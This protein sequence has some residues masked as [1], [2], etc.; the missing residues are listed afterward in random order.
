MANQ[1]L[2]AYIKEAL[3]Q[4]AARQAIEEALASSGW[5]KEEVAEAFSQVLPP[6]AKSPQPYYSVR[7]EHRM[8]PLVEAE[9]PS[10]GELAE[11]EALDL[12]GEKAP[13]PADFPSGRVFLRQ[14][15]DIFRDRM[16]IFVG[17]AAVP[18]V[19]SFLLNFA[20]SLLPTPSG[21]LLVLVFYFTLY[22]AIVIASFILQV[23]G[24]AALI[25]VLASEEKEIGVKE[26]YQ[27]SRQRLRPFLW[28]EVILALILAGGTI[29]FVVPGI[30]FSVWFV[31]APFILLTEDVKSTEA[32]FRSRYYIKGN[33]WG[34]VRRL[35]YLSFFAFMTLVPFLFLDLL[36]DTDLTSDVGGFATALI[37]VPLATTYTFLIYK[38][39]KSFKKD[40]KPPTLLPSFKK[41]V[42]VIAL[43]GAL[44]PLAFG[45]VVLLALNPSEVMEGLRDDQRETD[46]ASIQTALEIHYV[47]N[48]SYPPSLDELKNYFEEVPL[49]PLTDAPYQY[50]VAEEGMGYELCA[51]FE[52]K[53][54]RCV[55]RNVR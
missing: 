38:H 29:L 31:L 6:S 7:G 41:L 43:L 22:L 48:N 40:E 10:E 14:A 37:W 9:K 12:P 20:A 36:L 42:V 15:R 11:K 55:G 8:E 19:V 33:W 53:P 49:D 28:L 35:A 39:L 46:L 16:G 32:L 24:T 18:L 27:K 1:E 51:N 26:A 44:S 21:D 52:G 17:I 30:I 34:V 45:G 47:Q 2:T 3:K 4:G 54:R 5:S 13:L 25:V 23:W 50:R